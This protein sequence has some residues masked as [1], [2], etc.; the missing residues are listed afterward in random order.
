MKDNIGQFFKK[1]NKKKN[2]FFYIKILTDQITDWSKFIRK[3]KKRKLVPTE[4]NFS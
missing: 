3:V 1:E 4:E 2:D